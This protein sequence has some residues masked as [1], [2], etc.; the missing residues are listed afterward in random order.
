MQGHRIRRASQK[1]QRKQGAVK[2][3]HIMFFDVRGYPGELG[4]STGYHGHWT[5]QPVVPAAEVAP[6]NS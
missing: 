2:V 5:L 6:S 4:C 1:V 3:M